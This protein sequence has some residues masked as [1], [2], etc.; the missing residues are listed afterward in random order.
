MTYFLPKLKRCGKKLRLI[1]KKLPLI[2]STGKR[3]SRRKFTTTFSCGRKLLVKLT[4]TFLIAGKEKKCRWEFSAAL[5]LTEKMSVEI[6]SD[7][8]AVAEKM[9]VEISSD[10]LAV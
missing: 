9:S 6:S 4:A 5:W 10:I 3:K 1:T 2:F 7:I 8:L